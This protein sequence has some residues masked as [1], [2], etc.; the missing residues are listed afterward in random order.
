MAGLGGLPAL[1]VA[2]GFVVLFFL[3][4]T[5]CSAVN[6][7][8]ANLLGWRAKTLEDAIRNLVGDSRPKV[9]WRDRL[10]GGG[11]RMGKREAQPQTDVTP[12][13]F[14]H[15]RIKGLV[16][17][18]ESRWRRRSRPSYLPPRAFSLALAETLARGP[19]KG[20]SSEEGDSLWKQT[21]DEILER[22]T[23]AMDGLPEGQLRSLA[24]KAALNAGESLDGFRAQ[25]ERVFDDSMERASGW[26]KR[27]VQAALLVL[28]A[29]IAVGLNVDT[30]RVATTLWN[31]QPLRTAVAARAA[32]QGTPDDAATAVEQVSELGLPVGWGDNAP[33]NILFAIP[34]WLMTIAAL[35]L[36]APFWFDLLSRLSRL[37]GAGVP[38]RP[39]SLSDTAGTVEAERAARPERPVVEQGSGSDGDARE[40]DG[41]HS[42]PEDPPT[43]K[44]T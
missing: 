32:A 37:R 16:R 17:N 25:V 3:L 9:G 41:K 6:E 44:S 11:G 38:E 21:D 15:W 19:A 27:K 7:G 8:I 31:D 43:G 36:G 42:R 22:V 18:P 34:G 12:A 20:D 33:D 2:I 23:A 1:D 24:Q 40:A 10:R 26:Y 29:L 13:L 4:S 39:R 28:A 35:N 30:V 5:V 14:D